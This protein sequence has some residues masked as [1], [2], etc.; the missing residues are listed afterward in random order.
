[1]PSRTK[2]RIAI[3]PTGGANLASVRAGLMRAGG[4]VF[5]VES[6]QDIDDA[7]G[8]VLPGVGAFR[9]AMDRLTQM[10][11][12]IDAI[13]TRIAAGRPT[14]CVCLGLQL[15]GRRSDESPGVSGLGSVDVDVKAWPAEATFPVPHMGWNKITCDAGCRFLES[16]YAYFAHSFRATA[17]PEP[18]CLATCDYGGTIIAGAEFGDVVAC[19]FHPELSGAWGKRL[20]ARW[21]AAA[22]ASREA[23]RSC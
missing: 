22:E 7:D 5:Q 11:C 19:Q 15:L 12:V 18:W 1:M 17:W 14:L 3:V 16:G 9:P 13:R 8:V 6:A 20:L 4:S 10:P 21:V 23:M 2:P